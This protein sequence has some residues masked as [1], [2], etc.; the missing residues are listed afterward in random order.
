MQ[1]RPLQPTL[2]P[3]KSKTTPKPAFHKRSCNLYTPTYDP[4]KSHHDSATTL[5]G[6]PTTLTTPL[7]CGFMRRF[8]LPRSPINRAWHC[9]AFGSEELLWEASAV[10]SPRKRTS[11][12]VSQQRFVYQRTGKPKL[13]DTSLMQFSVPS[14]FTREPPPVRQWFRS[15]DRRSGR[16]SGKRT[17]PCQIDPSQYIAVDLVEGC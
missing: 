9:L 13:K 10:P 15:T 5:T 7:D 12:L 6:Q 14:E 3:S 8:H 11:A 16:K 4:S 2:P 17:L 1:L